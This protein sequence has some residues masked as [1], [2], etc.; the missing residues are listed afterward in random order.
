MKKIIFFAVVGIFSALLILGVLIFVAQQGK[1]RRLSS[2]NDPQQ[3]V[4]GERDIERGKNPFENDADRDG[5]GDQKE[6]ELGTNTTTF[7][8]DNDGL[9]DALEIEI[10]TDPTVFDTDADGYGDGQE[11]L[12]G[13]NP[14]GPGLKNS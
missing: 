13:Y 11:V 7:D 4:N 3:Q 5:I 14:L 12:G 9:S 8:S 6:K 2:Q 1:N 10:K